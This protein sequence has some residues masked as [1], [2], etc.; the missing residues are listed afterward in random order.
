MNIHVSAFRWVPQ[1]AQGYVR[2]LRVRWALEEAGLP[3]EATLID[4]A[5]QATT[6]Y[7]EWQPFGQVPAYRDDAVE[8]FE[9][10]AIVLHLA[11]RSEAL[12]PADE[13]GRA[14]VTTW[15]IAALNSVEPHVQNLVQLD[16]F[17]AG[18]AWTKERRPQAEAILCKRLTALSAWLGEREFL[19]DRF[20]AGDLMM[21]MVLR[22]LADT[23]LLERYAKLGAY[24]RRCT[25]RPTFKRA[26]E[27]QLQPF[28]ENAPAA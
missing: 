23:G 4:P 10:G 24:V 12:A 6:A 17:Y 26:L 21:T 18:E 16:V 15:V 7:R 8:I 25:D 19:E 1:F 22:E 14:R 9:S 20:T 27:A 13:A 11:M 2:D 5:I 28:R 3:Y